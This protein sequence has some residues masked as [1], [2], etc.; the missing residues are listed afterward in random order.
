L[1]LALSGIRVIDTCGFGPASLAAMTMADMG[2]D[3]IKVE[4]PPGG[5]HRGVGEGLVYYPEQEDEAARMVA[6][7][8]MDRNKK[9]VAINMRTESGQAVFQRL[10]KSS[11]VVLES[12]R[13]GVMDRMNVGYAALSKI[14]PR[15]IYCAVSGYGQTGPYRNY[16]GH[17]GNYAGFGGILGMTGDR[18]GGPPVMALNI[19]ADMAVAYLNG[20]VGILLALYAREKTGR[21]QMV[22][23]SM[24][25]GVIGLLA[26]V[27]GAV[28]YPYSGA[29]PV[30]GETLTSGN[31]P[32]YSVYETKDKKWLSIC[33]IEPRFWANMCKAIGREDLIPHEFA[34]GAKKDEVMADLR[35]IFLTKTRDEWFDM[36][37]KE[38]VPVGKVL[39]IDEV[40]KDPQ[41]LARQMVLDVAHAKFGKIKQVGIS[42]KLSDTPGSIRSLAVPL[43]HNT[44]EVMSGLGYSKD[45][46][47]KLRGEGA[48]H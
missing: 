37:A 29:L 38:D 47:Q 41:A 9:R 30:R 23:I 33:P 39:D 24:M 6:H 46:I 48:I 16:V 8:A 28:E 4:M 36:L 44:E 2:S 15:L 42:I 25:D 10:A 13:P 35:R 32:Y 26:G 45:E 27:P 5:G 19:V 14:N 17:D 20:L 7:S 12:F 40:F 31:N 34:A 18:T 11:D 1:A 3:V 43:S 22:D 21:G